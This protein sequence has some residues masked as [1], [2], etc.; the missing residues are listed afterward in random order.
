MNLQVGMALNDRSLNARLA[1]SFPSAAEM[2]EWLTIRR[3][4]ASAEQ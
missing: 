2:G 3:T 1:D 4:R